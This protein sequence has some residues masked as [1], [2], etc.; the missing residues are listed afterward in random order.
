MAGEQRR[1]RWS[2]LCF[3]ISLLCFGWVILSAGGPRFTRDRWWRKDLADRFPPGASSQSLLLVNAGTVPAFAEVRSPAWP[4]ARAEL[5]LPGQSQMVDVPADAAHATEVRMRTLDLQA[6]DAVHVVTLEPG[7]TRTTI[8][9]DEDGEVDS[10]T[11]R[12]GDSSPKRGLVWVDTSYPLPVRIEIPF[13]AHEKPT[14]KDLE[15]RSW[16]GPGVSDDS[17]G[18]A[19]AMDRAPSVTIWVPQPTSFERV[20]EIGSADGATRLTMKPDGT[21]ARDTIPAWKRLVHAA[22]F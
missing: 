1:V 20:F 3:G 10:W 7:W 4:E 9:V 18:C 17:D 16:I 11:L 15:R 6:R 19:Y 22:S 8:D 21:V 14:G 13:D 2:L 12:G 5:L